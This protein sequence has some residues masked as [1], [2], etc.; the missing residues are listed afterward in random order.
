L[1][2]KSQRPLNVVGGSPVE[3]RADEPFKDER[4]FYGASVDFGHFWGNLEATL[5]AI[6]QRDRA[7]LDRQAIGGELR[8]ID[9]DKSAFA[10]IDY[11]VHFQE[12]NAAM[13][14]GSW[15]LPDKSTISAGID[16][17][18]S[19]YLTAW[20]A[21]QGQPFLTLYDM[22]KL[23][24]KEEVDQFAIDRTPTYPI[25]DPR[26]CLSAR[27]ELSGEPG[28]NRFQPFRHRCLGRDRG[29]GDAN[30]D[31]SVLY[32][33]VPLRLLRRWAKAVRLGHNLSLVESLPGTIASSPYRG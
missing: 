31:R 23:H 21:L 16:Y 14:S 1:A 28:C 4:Y 24:S 6:E 19:P 2:G 3:R 27:Q 32:R 11:D 7:V 15:T 12:I 17:R 5:F 9:A 10:L 8:Y 30:R 13:F 20:N 18:K 29:R 25:G 22:L 33:R 26:L